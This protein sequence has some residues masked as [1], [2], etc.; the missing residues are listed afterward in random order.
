[1]Q[2]SEFIYS[3]KD[4][5]S[6]HNG[7]CLVRNH[8]QGYYIGPYQRGY[9]WR[10]AAKYDQIPTLLTDLYDAFQQSQADVRNQEYFLQYITVKRTMIDER[11]YFELIDGQQ[12][13]TSISI[14]YHVLAHSFGFD[15]LTE[16]N[17]KPLVIYSRYPDNAIFQRVMM[18]LGEHAYNDELLEQQ[19]LFYMVRAARCFRD[20]FNLLRGQKQLRHFEI[21]L[22]ENVKLILNRED[23]TTSAEEVFLNLNTNKVPLTD[24]ELVKGLLLTR[25]SRMDDDTGERNFKEITEIR[26]LMGKSWDELTAWLSKPD[27]GAYFFEK[28][29]ALNSF[30]SLI[31]WKETKQE[32]PVVE[33]FRRG[34]AKSVRS[35]ENTYVQFNR[36]ME[37][38][39]R[40]LD[41]HELLVQIKQV[42]RRLRSWY[43]TPYVY[44]LLGY[45]LETSKNRVGKLKELLR[46]DSNE[47]VIN[48]MRLH[49]STFL[50]ALQPEKLEFGKHNDSIKSLLLAISVFPE[51]EDGAT[52]SHYRF[53]FF[54]YG[55]QKWTIEHIF[56]QNPNAAKYDV[57]DDRDWVLRQIAMQQLKAEVDEQLKWKDLQNRVE[58]GQPVSSADMA[59]LFDSFTQT[60]QLG[61][62]ALLPGGVNSA[63]SNK[64][65]NTKRKVL[66]KKISQGNFVPKHTLDVFSKMLDLSG[67]QATVPPPTF[68]SSLVTWTET[69]AN[70][71]FAWLANR[72]NQ[73]IILNQLPQ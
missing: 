17:G 55:D 9:K 27:V 13:I 2:S 48:T 63:L 35:Q 16:N 3:I 59:W 32:L 37:R 49:L 33:L 46:D 54:T 61:N 42:Y 5:F 22:R 38:I 29:A 41:A 39:K 71:H 45:Y 10:S 36:Y 56:P 19:D 62:L 69:D 58:S 14:L 70:T 30:L 66:L 20:F 15:N 28:T 72:I 18:T 26:L 73:L 60:D 65:F 24:G 68:D 43:E 50:S 6:T 34:L 52:N 21:F 7:G 4:I 25:A 44:N 47:S 67:L 1:M 40:P 53:D 11:P 12:R 51:S 23:E 57:A 8:V 31:S 64:F